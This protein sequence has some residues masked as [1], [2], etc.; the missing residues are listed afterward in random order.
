MIT[1]IALWW[2][3]HYTKEEKEDEPQGRVCEYLN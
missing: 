1:T 2:V 3:S